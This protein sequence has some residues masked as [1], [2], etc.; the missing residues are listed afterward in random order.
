MT[1]VGNDVISILKSQALLCEPNTTSRPALIRALC[2]I[3]HIE[4]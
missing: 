1:Q 3:A 4:C 2:D